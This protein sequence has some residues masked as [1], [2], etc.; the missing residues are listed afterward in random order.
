MPIEHVPI[1]RLKQVAV[2]DVLF[3][4][5]ESDHLKEC[6]ECFNQWSACIKPQEDTIDCAPSIGELSRPS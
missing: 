6:A 1:A 3:T 2:N 4:S 5:E